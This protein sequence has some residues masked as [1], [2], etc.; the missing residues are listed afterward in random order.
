MLDGGCE[1]GSVFAVPVYEDHAG[2]WWSRPEC[3]S[4]GLSGVEPSSCT[5]HCIR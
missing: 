4:D 1:A 5:T 3:E 2:I